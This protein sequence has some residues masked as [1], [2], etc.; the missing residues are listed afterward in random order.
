MSFVEEVKQGIAGMPKD[1]AAELA[2]E[3]SA[4]SSIL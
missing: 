3:M 4:V 1:K 2:A